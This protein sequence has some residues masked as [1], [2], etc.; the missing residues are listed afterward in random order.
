MHP[1]FVAL[2]CNVKTRALPLNPQ[3]LVQS[4]E[5]LLCFG[6]LLLLSQSWELLLDSQHLVWTWDLWVN[7]GLANSMHT[8]NRFWICSFPKMVH[9]LFDEMRH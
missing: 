1:R 3:C 8:L 7:T 2:H 5:L 9:W 4:I 6:Q